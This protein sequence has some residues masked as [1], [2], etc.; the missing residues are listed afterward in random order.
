MLLLRSPTHGEVHLGDNSLGDV[1][2]DATGVA[3]GGVCVSDKEDGGFSV[4]SVSV[5]S[6]DRS[7]DLPINV[8]PGGASTAAL[9]LGIHLHRLVC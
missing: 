2:A 3:M 6:R 7:R 5:E 9:I 4:P 8:W 1:G